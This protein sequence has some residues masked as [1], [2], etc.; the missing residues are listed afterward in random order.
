M[1]RIAIAAI[2]AKE[3]LQRAIIQRHVRQAAHVHDI[4]NIRV[5]W[6]KTHKTIDGGLR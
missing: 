2:D 3:T 1:L 4:V 5:R 6:I